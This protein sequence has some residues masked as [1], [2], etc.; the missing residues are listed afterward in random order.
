MHTTIPEL[1][2]PRA[3]ANWCHN[4]TACGASATGSLFSARF[5]ELLEQINVTFAS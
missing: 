2:I 5:R 4:I 3:F 1:R